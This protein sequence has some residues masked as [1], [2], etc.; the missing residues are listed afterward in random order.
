[1]TRHRSGWRPGWWW[2]PPTGSTWWGRP[3]PASSPWSWPTSSTQPRADGR[4]PPG[5]RRAGGHEE[6]PRD[7]EPPR[8]DPAA[9]HV[10]GGR[11]RA[12]GRRVRGRRLHPE[13]LVQPR[14][15]GGGMG[16]RILNGLNEGPLVV[17][18]RLTERLL[19]GERTRAGVRIDVLGDERRLDLPVSPQDL[20]GG[21]I[22]R[23][24]QG[25]ELGPLE[26]RRG[27]AVLVRPR[28]PGGHC[29][30]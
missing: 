23:R 19:P 29:K 3:R 11:V 5:H 15:P 16:R 9:L 14:A 2:R 12:S 26:R 17:C 6:D 21:R 4:E 22:V 25:G 27:D 30:L 24:R 8:G 18:A 28:D 13:V 7:G 10:R 20:D 1:M